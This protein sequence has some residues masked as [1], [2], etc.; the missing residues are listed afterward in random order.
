MTVQ[1]AA[2]GFRTERGLVFAEPDGRR[3]KMTLYIPRDDADAPDTLRPGMV[4]IHGGGWAIGT[5]YQQAWYCRQFARSGYVVMTI[6][7]RMMPKYPFP[8]CLHDCKAAVRWLRLNA[9]QWRVDPQR[10]VTFGASAGG[11]LAAFLA[12]TG[13]EHGF[14]GDQNPGASSAVS[15]A[16]SLY[17]A[18]DLT[19]YR[20]KKRDGLFARRGRR[21]L[22]A[23]VGEDD[24]NTVMDAFETASPISYVSPASCP[25]LFVHG[26][27]DMVVPF[28]MSERFHER[29][30]EQGVPTRLI[31]APGRN[32]GFDYVH[33][34]QRRA[35]FQEML[36][37]LEEHDR[38]TERAA[39]E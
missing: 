4:L 35:L 16:V 30:K 14:E 36:A 12:T 13:P 29:L 11:H 28:S 24:P 17:G 10:I 23:F 39:E 21:F 27:S 18:V 33:M 38:P 6:D 1:A 5:R 31:P 26:T 34:R 22:R 2:A 25:M 8:N 32:H 9:E 15:A 7:Y 37:F 20:D 3:L 19:Q